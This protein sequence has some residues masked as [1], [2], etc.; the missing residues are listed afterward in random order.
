MA[1]AVEERRARRRAGEGRTRAGE[2]GP[3]EPLDLADGRGR[4]C[5]ERDVVVRDGG[6]LEREPDGLRA[7]GQA[8]PVDD[9][10]GLERRAGGRRARGGGA[11]WEAGRGGRRV[12]RRGEI[13]LGLDGSK[14]RRNARSR[15]GTWWWQGGQ[16]CGRKRLAGLAGRARWPSGGQPVLRTAEDDGPA[17]S[18]LLRAPAELAR[19]L[20][21]P[22]SSVA[23]ALGQHQ[24]AV[25]SSCFDQVRSLFSRPCSCPLRLRVADGRPSAPCRQRRDVSR[26]A[27]VN[28]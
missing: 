11:R 21:A 26:G 5:G 7:A 18:E 16:V 25:A 14:T 20:A 3:A 22:S 17:Q 15:R 10:W 28:A 1:S 8:G 23:R 6:V 12:S 27:F 4:V 19:Q 2:P 24:P 9:A 13:G